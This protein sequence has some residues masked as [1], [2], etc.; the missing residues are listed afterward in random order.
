MNKALSF[1]IDNTFL[2]IISR[3]D[4]IFCGDGNPHSVVCCLIKLY[5]PSSLN[6]TGFFISNHVKIFL[7]NLDSG[8][9][10]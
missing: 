5:E 6:V 1:S 7:T 2:S 10:I 9:R 8:T 3:N 4:K